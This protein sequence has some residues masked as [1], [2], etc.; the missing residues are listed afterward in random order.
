MALRAQPETRPSPDVLAALV[1]DA[2]QGV[3]NFQAD[4]P[5]PFSLGGDVWQR[6]DVQYTAVDGTDIWG[7]IMTRADAGQEVV[8]WAEAPAAAYNQLESTIFLTLIAD[9]RLSVR[10]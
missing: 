2:G 9:M 7:F 5:F 1:R 6:V 4:D 10:P 8:A 3:A